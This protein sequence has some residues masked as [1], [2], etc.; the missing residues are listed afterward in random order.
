MDDAVENVV[1][2]INDIDR[3]GGN[4]RNVN[5]LTMPK[6][7][8]SPPTT[9]PTP[10]PRPA[11]PSSSRSPGRCPIEIVY[12]NGLGNTRGNNVSDLGYD[13]IPLGT[14]DDSIDGGAGIGSPLGGGGK[15]P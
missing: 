3:G 10:P 9:R 6:A 13:I 14:G 5:A 12:A 7:T 11:A 15:T 2:R 4:H 8:R 1:F